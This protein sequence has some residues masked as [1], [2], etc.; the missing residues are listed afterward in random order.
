METHGTGHGRNVVENF[1]QDT[2]FG[3][4]SPRPYTL[5]GGSPP[6]GRGTSNMRLGVR[7]APH[8]V[9]WGM[10]QSS[11]AVSSCGPVLEENK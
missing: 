1:L 11:S 8:G 3:H 7:E 10:G 2:H 6:I 4:P 9:G 5:I